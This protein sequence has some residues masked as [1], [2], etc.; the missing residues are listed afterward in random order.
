[1]K[2]LVIIAIVGIALYVIWVK[3]ENRKRK[4]AARDLQKAVAELVKP[5][6]L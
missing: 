3:M 5:K 4:I 2:K 1:M 6:L